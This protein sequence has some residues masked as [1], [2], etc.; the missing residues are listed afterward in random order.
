[1]LSSKQEAFDTMRYYFKQFGIGVKTGI[2]VPNEITGQT[3]K[4]DSQP[5][6]LLDFAMGQYETYTPLQ[7]AQYVSTIANGGYRM[8]PKLVKE[9]QEQ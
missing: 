5:G 9:I 6:F 1:S 4:V 7:W 3:R 8:Q 2:D